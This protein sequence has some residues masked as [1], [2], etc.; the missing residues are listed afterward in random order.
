MIFAD[1]V[2]DDAA[3]E[4][5]CRGSTLELWV[6]LF[7]EHRSDHLSGPVCHTID[8]DELAVVPAH[9]PLRDDLCRA[10]VSALKNEQ[11]LRAA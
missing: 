8:G 11:A 4:G 7:M 10:L 6:A 5:E 2:Y 1:R 9:R 3:R